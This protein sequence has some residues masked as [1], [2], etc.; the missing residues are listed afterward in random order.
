V[1]TSGWSGS[2]EDLSML[3]IV[4]EAVS[5]D[6]KLAIRYRPPGREAKERILDPLGLVAKGDTWYLVA[7]TPEGFRTYR[8]SRI[9]NARL[10]DETFDRPAGFDLAAHWEAATEE[11]RKGRARYEATLR[12]EP[13][14]A[15]SFQR[16]RRAPP[17]PP[18]DPTDSEGWVTMR[19]LFEDEEQAR[20]VTLGLG[21]RVDILEP[22]PLRKAVAADH[23]A[24]G[25]RSAGAGA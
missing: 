23:A 4:Q 13:E 3:P 1:D 8:V 14:A 20:F 16:W 17:R 9:E 10:L 24:A 7:R 22:K 6:R 15:A 2:P 5:R 18:S 21:P 11:L 12:L 19:V 25:R